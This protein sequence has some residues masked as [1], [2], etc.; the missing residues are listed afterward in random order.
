MV[1]KGIFCAGSVIRDSVFMVDKLPQAEHLAVVHNNFSGTGGAGY[2]VPVALRRLGFDGCLAVA[3]VVGQ[4]K[5]GDVVFSD[6]HAIDVETTCLKRR[7]EMRTSFTNVVTEV[8]SGRRTFFHYKGASTTLRDDEIEIDPK[9]FGHLHL[10][11][12]ALLDELD[13]EEAEY[14]TNSAKLLSRAKAM[15]LSTSVDTASIPHERFSEVFCPVLPYCDYCIIN[16]LEAGRITGNFIRDTRG[17]L[18]HIELRASASMLLAKGNC[19]LVV[20]HFLE[21]AFALDP[22]G[23]EFF[24]P[25]V[26]IPEGYIHGAA[27]AGDAFVAGFL[28]GIRMHLDISDCLQQGAFVAA[29]SLE[30]PTCTAGITSLETC[31]QLGLSFGQRIFNL[32]E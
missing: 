4:D 22:K 12:V 14:G 20:I 25:S 10:G 7:N 27:G 29:K 26:N 32:D 9:R 8:G 23:N 11:Y 15:G 30:H 1:Q 17:G 21:G 16:E 28:L 19:N 2:N 18:N 5:S 31:R 6:L 3:G 13:D 24:E